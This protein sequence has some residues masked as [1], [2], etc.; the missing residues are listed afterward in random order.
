MLATSNNPTNGTPAV[1]N[2]R[3]MQQVTNWVLVPVSPAAAYLLNDLP[4]WW[5]FALLGGILG[6]MGALSGSFSRTM[7]D[8]VLTFCFVGQCILFTS[9]LAGHAWQI[10]SHMMFF[11]ALAIISTL[12][13]PGALIFGT[14]L[15]AGHH[16]S[17]SIFLP[18]L[19]YPS[20]SLVVNLERTA[21]HA[22]IVLLES[23]V[24]LLGLMKRAAAENALQAERR[25]SQSQA[26]AAAMAEE[27]ANE[28]RKNAEFVVQ[29]LE[30][31]LGELAQGKLNCPITSEFPPQY[32]QLRHS[33]NAAIQKLGQTIDDVSAAATRIGANTAGLSQS[34]DDLS[35]R[36]ENQAA[37]L[38]ET[39]A[40]MEQLAASVNSTLD[41]ARAADNKASEIRDEAEASGTVVKGA[42]DAMENIKES[43]RQIS[44][45]ISVIE[46]I[47]F[48]TNLLA[49]NAGVEA[50]RAGDAGK[51]F[52]V[53]A[54]EVGDL[55]HRSAE[56]A[57]EIKA[58]IEQSSQ[59]VMSGVELVGRAGEAIETVV[60]RFA[61]ISVSISQVADRSN[62][63][64]QG[65][66]EINI[67]VGNLDKVTQRNAAMVNDL[68]SNGHALGDEANKLS[69]LMQRFETSEMTQWAQ[70]NAA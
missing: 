69:E 31:Q 53:V 67:G 58:L 14:V 28:S 2:E 33:F 24:L 42:V 8:Y 10:D 6:V 59:Q 63:Q 36:T 18:A 65:L 25:E 11:A 35:R 34:S 48:Q 22:V 39:A 23:G 20:A 61:E 26:D 21:V 30:R 56:A 9:A 51:G 29:T 66:N 27:D 37:T 5:M 54:N 68:V 17:L 3:L 50:A 41:D 43:S 12:N 38:E 15:V 47:A 44:K 55:A 60:A 7:H 32:Q 40:A 13:N 70:P 4:S 57:T 64:S 52:A 45:I 19:V 62:D 49:L 16:L 46:D 1:G